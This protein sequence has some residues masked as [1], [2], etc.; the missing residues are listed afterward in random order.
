MNIWENIKSTFRQQNKLTILII[1]NVS[2]FLLANIDRGIM[3]TGLI[4]FIE[5]PLNINEF[6]F[7]FW[8]IFTYMFT[9]VD[10]GH[11]F[12]NLILLFFSGQLFYSV[13]GEKRLLYVYVMSGI[14]GGALLLILGLVFPESFSGSYL[15]GASASVLGIV[16]ALAIYTPNMPVFLFGLIEMRYK[17]FA[18][19]IFILSTV[20]DFA[21]NTGGKIAH[22]GGALFG[23]GYSYFLR[24]GKDIAS[25][26][27][28]PK[29]KSPLKTVH[30]SSARVYDSMKNSDDKYLD[31][32]LDKISKSGYDSLTKKEKDDLFKLSQ[33]K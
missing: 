8:T 19:L 11:V 33:K 9:H 5:L 21:V 13:L 6:I 18:V 30:G 32:L 14:C 12:F 3:H 10:L 27:F 7:R 28:I 26:S 24:N 15:I 16:M 1:I 4:R 2:V 20:I 31:S 22:I 29:K 25:F 23:L 17:Y